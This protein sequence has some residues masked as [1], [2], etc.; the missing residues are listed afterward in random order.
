MKETGTQLSVL[1][2]RLEDAASHA[3]QAATLSD[4]QGQAVHE[5][6]ESQAV[7]MEETGTL[8][9]NFVSS[10]SRISQHISEQAAVVDAMDTAGK[11][12]SEGAEAI[13]SNAA[14]TASFTER[15]AALTQNSMKAADSLNETMQGVSESSQSISDLVEVVEEFVE[16]TNL[17]SM[18]AAIEA[19]HAG[20]AGSGFAIVAQEIKRLAESQQK[21]V[22]GIRDIIGKI[23]SQIQAGADNAE[24][25]QS[26][27]AEITRGTEEAAKKISTV[28]AESQGQKGITQDLGN[29]VEGVSSAFASI[30]EEL[31]RQTDYSN[32]VR[33]AVDTISEQSATMADS[34]E[35]IIDAISNVQEVITSLGELATQS[36]HMTAKLLG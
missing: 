35:K 11:R 25:L 21:Q 27:L 22:T 1:G 18:N 12:L 10:I 24:A 2:Q 20:S 30:E 29:S 7:A 28:L 9:N 19:A 15:L 6:A 31:G 34:T 36:R 16:Q 33:H 4:E 14:D 32:Q 17:L 23:V 8:V 26:S 5:K 3:L 13:V